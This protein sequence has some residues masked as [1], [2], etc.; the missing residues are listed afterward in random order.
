MKKALLLVTIALIA[1]SAALAATYY[2]R[3][4]GKH[5][6]MLAGGGSTFQEPLVDEW[7]ALARGRGLVVSYQG[8]G[9][10]AGISGLLNG[11]YDFAGTDVPLP[12]ETYEKYKGKLVQLPIA[13]GA[14]AIV[15]NVP[16]LESA[17]L[18][19]SA[20]TL[21][22]IFSGTISYW[23][24]PN[25]ARDNP[26]VNLPHAQIVVVYR[27]DASGTT[28][29]LTSYLHDLCPSGWKAEWVGLT[30][31]SSPIASSQRGVGARG[32]GALAQ[33]VRNT[34]YSIGYVELQYASASGLAV[35]AVQS[36]SGPFVKPTQEEL[37]SAA[38]VMFVNLTPFDDW[39][40]VLGEIRARLGAH[41][42]LVSFTYEVF[43]ASY[44]DPSKGDAVR[45]WIKLILTEG[46]A[47]MLPGYLP[48]PEALA[49]SLLASLGLE[50]G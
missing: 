41:Y 27:A 48:L 9:S 1:A 14:V 28:A 31:S 4:L 23:D 46:Q 18:N 25:I 43:W 10:G 33:V 5:P 49:R 32:S 45:A 24:D 36:F 7:A 37:A 47:H 8:V 26:G 12:H 21:A 16:G 50:G 35:A 30:M 17:S 6:T 40:G 13:I 20:C 38:S 22:G 3:M 39:S 44:E 19:L 42:P 34:P 2:A 11:V 29:I 15:Y